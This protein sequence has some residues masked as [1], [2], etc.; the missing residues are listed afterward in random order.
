M[1]R[2][3]QPLRG[4][5]SQ[6]R[7][8]TLALAT[9]EERLVEAHSQAAEAFLRAT[10]GELPYQRALEIFNRVVDVPDRIQ[11]AVAVRA[12]AGLADRPTSTT[13]EVAMVEG[14]RGAM[15]Q[16]ALRIRGRR[17]DSLRAR[18]EKEERRARSAVEDAYLQGANLIV[19]E[20]KDELSPVDAV[21]FYI[22]A[23][24]IEPGWSE[25]IF[26]KA[27]A[28]TGSAEAEGKPEADGLVA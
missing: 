19:E 24:G 8:V 15:Q 2:A 28:S 1:S 21:Q 11:E 17:A 3:S 27:V 7:R 5:P 25:R 6:R 13:R 26:H 20:L 18:V 4:S 16:I 9:A 23:L 10:D 12:L 14:L 22:E